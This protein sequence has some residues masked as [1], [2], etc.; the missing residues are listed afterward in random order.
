MKKY[1][2]VIVG[3]G[4]AGMTAAMY[5]CRKKLKTVIISVDIGG[6][7]NLTSHIENYPGTGAMHGVELMQ[8]FKK[9]TEAFGAEFRMGKAMKVEKKGEQDLRIH[10][11][12]GE[13]YQARAVILAFGKVSRTLGIPGED[14]F[15]GRGV[16]TCVTCDGPLFKGK[17]VTVVGGGNSAVE[18]AIEM[19]ALAKKVYVV[20][21]RKQFTADETSLEKMKK[22]KNVELVFDSVITEVLG[23]KFVTGV[24]TENVV[25]KAKRKLDVQG[26]FLEIG[27]LVDTSMVKDL[28]KLNDKK[29]IIVD[30]RCNTSCPG[31]FAAGDV[32]QVPFKQTVI[33]AGEGA[34][35]A[36]ECHRYLTGGKGV[37][38]DWTT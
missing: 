4:A 30:E 7:T 16:S 20:H 14:K 6:Q 17:D 32:T 25:T 11:A 35:A 38:I 3:G 18:G 5:T 1:D 24:M 8:R 31:L 36:L 22:L 13:V 29:E 33:S 37:S 10:M 26:M 19:A 21:R 2:I 34:K 27:Y 15:M 23:N 9:D 28:V 12:D